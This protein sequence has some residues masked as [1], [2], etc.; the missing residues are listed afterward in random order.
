MTIELRVPF[1]EKDEATEFQQ[2]LKRNGCHSRLESELKFHESLN[3]R[4]TIG[5]IEKFLD[6]IEKRDSADEIWEEEEESVNAAREW[7]DKYKEEINEFYSK[8]VLNKPYTYVDLLTEIYDANPKLLGNSSESEENGEED[9]ADMDDDESGRM[10]E[11]KKLAKF[12]VVTECLKNNGCIIE[13]GDSHTVT[14]TNN[15]P[16]EELEVAAVNEIFSEFSP[17]DIE[18]AGISMSLQ[19]TVDTEYT[20]V[21]G[22]EFILMDSEDLA[23][24]LSWSEGDEDVDDYEIN[25]NNEALSYLKSCSIFVHRIVDIV[26][27]GPISIADL[28]KKLFNGA[29]SDVPL[30]FDLAD[31]TLTD[32]LND[33]KKLG[34]V[35]F[36]NGMVKPGK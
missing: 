23:R 22:P 15:K 4:S 10:E 30:T 16:I 21:A 31:E 35:T 18:N 24:Y 3:F 26:K 14:F 32:T 2:Y 5:N 13:N 34:F 8:C 25:G 7:V 36:K 27:E 28:Q 29:G 17:E 11:I 19:S 33:L 1:L 20:V 9:T 12:I 6:D